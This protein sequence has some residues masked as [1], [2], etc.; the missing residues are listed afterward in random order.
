[1]HFHPPSRSRERE[2]AGGRALV[3]QTLK[4]KNQA[5]EH[6]RPLAWPASWPCEVMLRTSDSTSTCGLVAMTSASYAEGRQL[7][8][9]QVYF[10]VPT[11]G[12]SSVRTPTNWPWAVSGTN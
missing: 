1:M 9:G 6:Y 2:K 10:D 11:S 4:P 5:Q 12:A 8:P 3:T 7:D